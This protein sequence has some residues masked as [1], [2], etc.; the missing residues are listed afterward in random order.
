MTTGRILKASFT[1]IVATLSAVVGLSAIADA[2]DCSAAAAQ[3]QGHSIASR[4]EPQSRTAAAGLIACQFKN[5]LWIMSASGGDRRQL[6]H[7]PANTAAGES[8][9]AWSPDGSRLAYVN[10]AGVTNGTGCRL[11]VVDAAGANNHRVN[12]LGSSES[13]IGTPA[14]SPDGQRIAF[15]NMM[16][17]EGN[18][19]KAWVAL[20][21]YDFVTGQTTQL[22][23]VA[24]GDVIEGM[25]WSADG[26]GVEFSVDNGDAVQIGQIGGHRVRLVSSLRSVSVAS[27][28]VSTLAIAPSQS[29][30]TGIA[31]SPNGRSVAVALI[32]GGSERSA[33]LTGPM[34]GKP[35]HTVVKALQATTA[36]EAVSWSPSAKQLAYASTRRTATV[37]GSSGST[38]RVIT[39]SSPAPRPRP[40]GRASSDRR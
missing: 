27:H 39:R 5:H 35:T 26:L 17:L 20:F 12:V 15:A 11:W 32:R 37:C 4:A 9:P 24:T 16:N 34:G 8:N 13:V 40:G 22:C 28:Q 1:V 33:I 29:R 25:T 3:R 21:S 31:R 19:D 14:W 18:P 30:F 7:S 10:W 6:T 23:R 38:A 36:Y 2:A